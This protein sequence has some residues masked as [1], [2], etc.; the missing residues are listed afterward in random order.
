M[1]PNS[2]LSSLSSAVSPASVSGAV[3]AAG[4]ARPA[5]G[6]GEGDI[7]APASTPEGAGVSAL[8]GEAERGGGE[9]EFGVVCADAVLAGRAMSSGLFLAGL[10]AEGTLATV[11]RPDRLPADL[12]PGA[13]PVVVQ[14]VW[15]RALAVGLHAGRV[16]AAPRLYGDELA[17][18]AGVLEGAGF[19]A[20]AGLVERSRR[21]VAPAPAARGQA[22]ETVPGDGDGV[23]V[24]G[25]WP[26]GGGAGARGQ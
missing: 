25:A 8:P 4:G 2:R 21:L 22:G 3:P 20:M 15:D 12:F 23:G 5:P 9:A 18:L 17:R 10:I 26:V 1:N 6:S 7:P 19:R 13:D 14:A 11:G 16:S 24:P